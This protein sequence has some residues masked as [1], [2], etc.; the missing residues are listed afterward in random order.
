MYARRVRKKGVNGVVEAHAEL[1]ALPGRPLGQWYGTFT[2]VVEKSVAGYAPSNSRPRWKHY[3]PPLKTTIKSSTSATPVITK[4]GKGFR[5]YSAVGSRAPYAYYV[6]QGTG[7]HGGN[8]PYPAKILPPWTQ[9]GSSLYE[10]TWHPPGQRANHRVMIKGQE[11]QHFFDKGLKNG[12]RTMR[13][14]SKKE[15]FNP[16]K[17]SGVNTAAHGLDFAGNTPWSFAFDAQL[18]EWRA[19]RD[20]AFL[21]GKIMGKDSGRVI[22]ETERRVNE[23]HERRVRLDERRQISREERARKSALRSKKW[24]EKNKQKAAPQKPDTTKKNAPK[25]T[26]LQE[27]QLAAKREFAAFL[28]K[29]KGQLKGDGYGPEGFWTKDRAGN[30]KFHYWSVYVA[31]LFAEA[32]IQHKSPHKHTRA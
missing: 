21:S 20:V 27:A 26:P 17:D 29:A 25:L 11:G 32:G 1:L 22:R 5:L 7:I 15:P 19:W 16:F 13:M 2:K 18:R 3:G 23:F 10:H 4:A 8:G 14:R 30:R 24:R 28:Q 12:F 31:D 9:G 6:D